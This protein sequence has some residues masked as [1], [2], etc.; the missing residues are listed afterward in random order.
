M[1][2]LVFCAGILEFQSSQPVSLASEAETASIPISRTFS[3]L[4]GVYAHWAVYLSD[5][6]TLAGNDFDPASGRLLVAEGDAVSDL[7]LT[8]VDDQVPE[9]AE[10]YIVSLT[11]CSILNSACVCCNAI[12]M[13]SRLFQVCQA[14]T[15]P[16]LA[17]PLPLTTWD[18]L[19]V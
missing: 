18:P 14:R 19:R 11:G 15:V 8:P 3:L 4:G 1:F 2:N 10:S 9:L 13:L 7:V 5:G 16:P 6:S 12:R 17:L